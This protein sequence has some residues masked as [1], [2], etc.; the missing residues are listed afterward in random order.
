V[1][2][3]PRTRRYLLK[4]CE[5]RFLPRQARQRYCSD[6]RKAVRKWSRWKAQQRYRE[7][8]VGKEKRN[9]QTRRYR[10]LANRRKRPEPEAVSDAARVITKENF[11][12]M[13]AATGRAAM[14]DG[15]A[16]REVPLQRFCSH[17]CRRAPERLR[18][19]T[20]TRRLTHRTCR[21]YVD[22]K[23]NG[24]ILSG[25]TFDSVREHAPVSLGQ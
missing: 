10:E 23:T 5:Q 2:R 21:V 15:C 3:R 22:L 18:E 9:G 25:Y 20:T 12:L 16:N 4:G 1:K 14:R 6:C 24:Q 17:S 13:I 11:F 19:R 8:A 7:T